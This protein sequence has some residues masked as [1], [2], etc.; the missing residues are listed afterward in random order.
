VLAGIGSAAAAAIL[1]ASFAGLAL[2]RLLYECSL[3]CA[4]VRTPL[5]RAFAEVEPAP[6]LGPEP[7]RVNLA[8]LAE[9]MR[10]APSTRA[11]I[12]QAPKR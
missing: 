7:P 11:D 12:E 8:Y 3:A 9:Q 4:A 1:L 5:R 6:P 2:T 10:M